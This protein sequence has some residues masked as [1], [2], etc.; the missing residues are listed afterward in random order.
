MKIL[1]N[2]KFVF[3][4]AAF[5]LF[6]TF[7]AD[8]QRRRTNRSRTNRPAA[9]KPAPPT[10]NSTAVKQ[11]EQTVANQVRNLSQFLYLLGG[12]VITIKNIDN[13]AKANKVSQTAKQQSEAGKKG[14]IL[15]ISTFKNAMLKMEDDFRANPALK[16]YLLQ[17]TGVGETA[18]TAEDQARAGQFDQAGRTLIQL[19]D[20]LTDVLVA[21]K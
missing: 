1:L 18:T 16:P 13:E 12:S 3:L 19:I 11:A 15:T 7:T 14:I 10:A 2:S 17:L 20:Q 4:T 8:A 9:S 5:I 6:C 21:M